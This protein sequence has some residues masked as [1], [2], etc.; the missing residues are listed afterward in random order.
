M[1]LL[2]GKEVWD[3]KELSEEENKKANESDS[4]N[5]VVFGI[6]FFLTYFRLVYHLSDYVIGILVFLIVQLEFFLNLLGP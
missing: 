2:E 4:V 5:E 3:E 6:S 1:T